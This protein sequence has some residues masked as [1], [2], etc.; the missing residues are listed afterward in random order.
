MIA[1]IWS[2]WT[3][4]ADSDEYLKYLQ[5]TGARDCAA[6][7][8]NLGTFILRREAHDDAEFL[9][10][11]L[12]DSFDSVRLFSGP[13]ETKAVYYP[14]DR[15]ILRRLDPTVSHFEVAYSTAE[16]PGAM[17]SEAKDDSDSPDSGESTEHSWMPYLVTLR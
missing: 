9:F 10:L 14:E 8:G 3:R 1:R 16:D 6:T 7:E 5:E 2:G 4:R 17:R 12:W 15:R 11:T 13:D